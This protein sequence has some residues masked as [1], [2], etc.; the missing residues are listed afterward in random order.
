MKIKKQDFRGTGKVFSFTLVQ[1]LK[2]KAN[3]A[4]LVI[5]FLLAAAILPISVLTGGGNWM[6]FEQ[7]TSE[8]IKVYIANGTGY[9]LSMEPDGSFA[10]TVFLQTEM[11]SDEAVEVLEEQEVYVSLTKEEDGSFAMELYT[12]EDSILESE[13]LYELQEYVDSMLTRARCLALG[14]TEEQMNIVTSQYVSMVMTESAYK[15]STGTSFELA[16]FVQFGYSIVVMIMSLFAITYIIRSVVEEKSSKLVEFLIVSVRP[17]ALVT[18]KILASMVYVCILF[19]VMIVGF[20][21]SLLTLLGTGFFAE[22]SMSEILGMVSGMEMS[23]AEISFNLASLPLYILIV[24]VS[25]VL[26]YMTFSILAGLAGAS[27]SKTEEIQNATSIPTLV[28]MA[29]YIAAC[30]ISAFDSST[31][32]MAASLFPFISIFCAP[33]QFLLGSIPFWVLVLSWVLQLAVVVLLAIFA[34]SIYES[35]LMHRGSRVKL[36]DMISLAAKGTGKEH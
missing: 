22:L 33:A 16:Y 8:L 3:L 1:V 25:L 34:A 36:G 29:C 24:L 11:A 26:G 28:V 12:S 9:T 7:G 30:M 15:D 2:N 13:D 10:D 19:G 32:C 20:F 18:G 35:L 4:S 17:L 27:C 23:S 21:L 31:V 5:M 6:E 14:V